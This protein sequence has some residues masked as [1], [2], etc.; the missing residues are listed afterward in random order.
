MRGCWGEFL[1]MHVIRIGVV[2]QWLLRF[3]WISC[4]LG[5]GAR[6]ERGLLFPIVSLRHFGC[7]E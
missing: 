6:G 1:V 2:F 4:S 3:P 5:C 7:L